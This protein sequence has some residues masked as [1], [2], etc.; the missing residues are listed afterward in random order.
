M[1]ERICT[2]DGRSKELFSSIWNRHTFAI[3]GKTLVQRYE[4]THVIADDEDSEAERP[5][6]RSPIS[7]IE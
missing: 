2:I 6:S 5:C 7:S 4:E 1:R 3:P